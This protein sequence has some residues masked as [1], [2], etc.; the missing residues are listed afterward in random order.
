VSSKPPQCEITPFYLQGSAGKLF[1]I[2]YTPLEHTINQAV[3]ICPPFAEELNRSRRAISLLG[4][5]LASKG[6][7]MLVIDLYGTGDSE[8]DFSDACWSIWLDDIE[9]GAKWLKDKGYDHLSILGIRLG[10]ILATDSHQRSPHSFD[11]ITFWQPVLSGKTMMSQFLRIHLA[12][13]LSTHS[14][15]EIKE[16]LDSGS[17]VEIAGYPLTAKLYKDINQSRLNL[18]PIERSI[19]WFEIPADIGMGLA[20]PSQKLIKEQS[21]RSKN[22]TTHIMDTPQFWSLFDADVEAELI[23]E[24]CDAIIRQI[25]H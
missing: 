7:T 1:S 10:A 12:S 19:S 25:S 4:Q 23:T 8:G 6:V 15:G 2:T 18:N 24:T 13:E 17:N 3:I 20:R 21:N 9:C 22:I 5:A 14:N 16:Q 11:Q